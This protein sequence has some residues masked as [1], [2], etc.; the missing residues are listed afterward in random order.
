MSSIWEE[1]CRVWQD[2]QFSEVCRSKRGRAVHNVEQEQNLNQEKKV[3]IDMVNIN[4]VSFNSKCSV[5][6]V[7]LKTSNQARITVSYKVDTGSD[8]NIMPL[9][10][11]K[12]FF[13]RATKE[14]LAA[15]RHTDVQLKTYNRTTTQLGICKVKIEH[16]I[17]QKLCDFFVALGNGQVLLGMP[18]IE[19]LD[20]LTINCRR[21]GTQEAE[22]AIKCNTN[23][24][25]GQSSVC[26][27]LYTNPG[28][29]GDRPEKCYTNTENSDKNI[30]T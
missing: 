27:Q 20:I 1:V 2:K 23:I 19:T 21:V 14:Q 28:Q 16:N 5:I 10:I 15:T 18:D 13:P 26:E 11:Y 29:E 25:S 24:G 6:T 30:T 17:K 7:N 3:K 4:S 22:R 8:T 9:H 12:K